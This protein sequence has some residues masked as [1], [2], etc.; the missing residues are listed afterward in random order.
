MSIASF[1][2]ITFNCPESY[3]NILLSRPSLQSTEPARKNQAGMIPLMICPVWTRPS[4]Q[5]WTRPFRQP[6]AN[7]DVCCELSAK[8]GYDPSAQDAPHGI[9]SNNPRY[10][11]ANPSGS[12]SDWLGKPDRSSSCSA[13]KMTSGPAGTPFRHSNADSFA[14]DRE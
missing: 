9:A 14:V 5:S 10:C 2:A 3:V 7:D 4:L 13:A 1:L 6:F 8:H 11:L 12:A